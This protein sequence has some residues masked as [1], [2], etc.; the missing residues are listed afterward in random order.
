MRR[1]ILIAAILCAFCETTFARNIEGRESRAN[2][3]NGF[4][5]YNDHCY[6]VVRE[7]KN[8]VDAQ[9]DCVAKGGSLVEFDTDETIGRQEMRN[10]SAYL[11]EFQGGSTCSDWPHK[12]A[13]I[14]AYETDHHQFFWLSDGDA[15]T[16][17][18]FDDGEPNDNSD[19]DAIAIACD[20][21]WEWIDEDSNSEHHYICEART[22]TSTTATDSSTSSATSTSATGTTTIRTTTKCQGPPPC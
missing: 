18:N 7:K 16:W 1:I 5:A 21:T 8:H 2:C 6:L 22:E 20:R 9:A 15:L 17:E 10:L 4:A 14:G 19:N 3:P 12:V 13:W 11:N